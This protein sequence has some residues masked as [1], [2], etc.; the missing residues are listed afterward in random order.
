MYG[1][2]I[3]CLNP[4]CKAEFKDTT[5]IKFQ[6]SRYGKFKNDCPICHGTNTINPVRPKDLNTESNKTT[7]QKG[8]IHKYLRCWYCKN[9]GTNMLDKFGCCNRCGTNL[10]KYPTMKTLPYPKIDDETIAKQ[11]LG[12]TTH[13]DLKFSFNDKE[14][15]V[16][17]T[18]C[19]TTKGNYSKETQREILLN[20][21]ISDTAVS[22]KQFIDMEFRPYYQKEKKIEVKPNLRKIYNSW[23]Y[24]YI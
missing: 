14:N 9:N 6:D 23:R 3:F 17:I 11:V 21:G 19:N 20:K 2:K 10:K 8:K 22:T 5:R 4:F 7:S 12:N 24:G 18:T 16:D 15:T 1:D 13:T